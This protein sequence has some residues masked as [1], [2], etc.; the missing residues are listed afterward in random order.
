MFYSAPRNDS[1]LR[2]QFQFSGV[3]SDFS[4]ELFTN[5]LNCN[6]RVHLVGP[7]KANFYK[8]SFFY[9]GPS[10]WNSLPHHIKSITNIKSFK[11]NLKNR[12][13]IFQKTLFIFLLQWKLGSILVVKRTRVLYNCALK[14]L[15]LLLLPYYY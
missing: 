9:I 13:F 6:D 15:I 1:V 11:I 3:T 2:L 5:S 12:I 8:W 7:T 4:G 10:L 14:K